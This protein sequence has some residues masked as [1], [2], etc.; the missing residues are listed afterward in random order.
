MAARIKTGG[1]DQRLQRDNYRLPSPLR[2]DRFSTVEDTE[3][4][5]K[6]HSRLVPIE[7]APKIQHTAVLLYWGVLID[8]GTT[9]LD[10]DT[11]PSTDD[12]AAAAKRMSGLLNA[13]KIEK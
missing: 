12:Y 7:I 13:M 8:G 11:T 1:D 5:L 10:A 2:L 9:H 4:E 6:K 3:G